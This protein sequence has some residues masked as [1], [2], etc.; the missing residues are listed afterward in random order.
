MLDLPAGV[1]L[2]RSMPT[3][4]RTSRF[5]RLLPPRAY[6][7]LAGVVLLLV[8]LFA[9]AR[10]VFLL[11]FG[12]QVAEIGLW[13]LV[14]A[15]GIGLRFDLVVI[16]AALLPLVLVL[17]W[18]YSR[19]LS[20]L[21]TC[22]YGGAVFGFIFLL[23]LGDIRFFEE[24]D[25]HLNFHLFDYLREG[26]TAWKLILTDPGFWTLTGIW[27]GLMALF[28]AGV[29][30][31]GRLVRQVTARRSVCSTLGWL[32]IA[33][34]L[35][36]LGIRGRTDL[37]PID[38]GMAYFTES[39]LVNQL[40]LNGAYT[41]GRTLTEYDRDPRLSHKAAPD[42][43]PFV[44]TSIALDTVRAMLEV[45]GETWLEPGESLR[46]L[47]HQPEAKPGYR[48]NVVLVL[49]ESWS[50]RYTGAL[51]NRDGLT[52][53][54]DSLAAHGILFTNFFASGTRTSYGIA[55]TICSYPSLP[56]RAIL[57][58]YNA[59]HPFVSLSEILGRRGY[60]NGFVY[61]GD[62]AFDNMAGFLRTKKYDMVRGEDDFGAESS[63][64]KWGIPDHIMFQH[65]VELL[66]SL[67]RPFQL[68]I[69][70]LSN[71][72]P[73]DLPDSSVRKFEDSDTRSRILNAQV[74]ADYA[75]GRFMHRVRENPVFDSTIFVLTSD[76]ALFEL[77]R[78]TIDPRNF[79]SPLLIYAPAI[80]GEE[81]RRVETYA[82]QCDLLPTLMHLLGGEYEHESWGRNIFSV[83]ENDPGFVVMN[84]LHMNAYMDPDVLYIE[85]LGRSGDLLATR[86]VRRSDDP[87]FDLDALV[88]IEEPRGGA[89][90]VERAG[91]PSVFRDSPWFRQHDFVVIDCQK[92]K[93][94]ADGDSEDVFIEPAGT[95]VIWSDTPWRRALVIDITHRQPKSLQRART[96]MHHYM[97]A[98]E[99][100][101]IPPELR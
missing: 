83:P 26:D 27:L 46:R 41:L 67:P 33:L 14:A 16:L 65:S 60:F 57:K 97:Q 24:F 54:F 63:F 47:A 59:D 92:M 68:T 38:W 8:L 31:L 86:G 64:S 81:G 40:A 10:L 45:P 39:R 22:I 99:Q 77:G 76:H 12:R 91:R 89:P 90:F 34:A 96:R 21:I 62:A 69:L 29:W 15:F 80:L 5:R 94:I 79:H 72:T 98:A 66:D 61:G 42:R 85:S 28:F 35:A 56:G 30:L 55:A 25:A 53:H 51:G 70:T 4:D 19:R 93:L 71:H 37:A 18:L 2:F 36:F 100:L 87:V 52:P 32:V 74:Y 88:R 48:P 101:S 95:P 6:V 84:N 20:G 11:H 44:P 49:M 73:F 43:W 1:G 3:S 50:G 23:L 9:L 7:F 75:I 17:P 82:G 58:R 13:K 78:F